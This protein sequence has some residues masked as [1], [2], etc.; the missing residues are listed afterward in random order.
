MKDERK[1]R[2]SEEDFALVD[3]FRNGRFMVRIPDSRE[4]RTLRRNI[5]AYNNDMFDEGFLAS[6]MNKLDVDIVDSEYN[7]KGCG[8]EY[9]D[10]RDWAFN[11]VGLPEYMHGG[12]RYP[13][14]L[15]HTD[16]WKL[17]WIPPTDEKGVIAM[18][19][20]GKFP[21]HWGVTLGGR[22]DIFI[23]SKWGRGNVYDHPLDMVLESY[24]NYV[25]FFR[26]ED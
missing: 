26:V 15:L 11:N 8:A 12:S 17:S 23:R 19:F 1:S 20:D 13:N 24:G 6:E 21:R 7:Y 3:I 9:Y 22:G 4:R 16:T 5:S 25:G 18:Y 10:C 2:I 14:D